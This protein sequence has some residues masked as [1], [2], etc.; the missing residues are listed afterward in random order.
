MVNGGLI[1]ETPH[2]YLRELRDSDIDFVAEMLADPEVM[3]FW[4]RP[5]TRE[6]AVAWIQR[7]QERLNGSC[8]SSFDP[9]DNLLPSHQM[10]QRPEYLR[11][12]SRNSCHSMQELRVESDVDT[13]RHRVT[14]P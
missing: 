4:P 11:T 13:A 1:I 5:Y 12:Y 10:T 2:L 6:E 14:G 9:L 8:P 7:M 3:R